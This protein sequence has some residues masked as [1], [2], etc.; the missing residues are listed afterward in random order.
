MVAVN[1]DFF[2]EKYEL[3]VIAAA[4]ITSF[5]Y[6]ADLL[7]ITA[8]V[9]AEKVNSIKQCATQATNE[10]TRFVLC[11]ITVDDFQKLSKVK[12]NKTRQKMIKRIFLDPKVFTPKVK[13]RSY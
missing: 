4:A 8:C 7:A 5:L 2:I 11:V 13:R 6:S 10:N 3:G 9:S 12:D 1:V